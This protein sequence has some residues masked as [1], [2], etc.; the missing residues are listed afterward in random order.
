MRRRHGDGCDERNEQGDG[1]AEARA[2]HS[3]YDTARRGLG[4]S[5]GIRVAPGKRWRLRGR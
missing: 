5:T 1:K 3:N 2:Q 4:F